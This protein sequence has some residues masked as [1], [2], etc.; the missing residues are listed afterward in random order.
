MRRKEVESVKIRITDVT[1]V[2]RKNPGHPERIDEALY[3][4][5]GE[6]LETCQEWVKIRMFYG[7]EGWVKKKSVSSDRNI[8]K[9]RMVRALFADVKC[10]PEV[11]SQTLICL[12]R[13]ACVN[14][15]GR[16]K[17]GWETVC[18]SDGRQGFIPESALNPAID[19]TVCQF[20][21]MKETDQRNRIVRTAQSYL[22]VP[23][24]WGG[25][26]PCGIDC[27]GLTQ[28]TYLL[29][30]V[31]IYRDARLMQGYPVHEIAV[32]DKKPGDLLYF[33]GHIALYL[34]ENR[35]LHATAAEGQFCVTVNSLDPSAS[36]YREDLA[37]QLVTAGSIF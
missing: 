7:Y 13:G 31:I 23:Y 9:H 1:T 32:G 17:H 16:K 14:A 28:M 21:R 37:E 26:T 20:R 36:D 18:L 8:G 15:I 19:E 22:G 30:G 3:G 2:L 6:V 10:E 29:N 24:R 11:R 4:M 35:Y 33:P 12:P 25:K 27:S 5:G 34:G